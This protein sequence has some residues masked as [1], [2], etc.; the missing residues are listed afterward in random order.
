[1]HECRRCPQAKVHHLAGSSI[2]YI[3]VANRVAHA[4]EDRW[5]GARSRG[6]P[7]VA[8]KIIAVAPFLQETLRPGIP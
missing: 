4:K 8:W 6:V 5:P 1:M 3:A 7:Q 2:E